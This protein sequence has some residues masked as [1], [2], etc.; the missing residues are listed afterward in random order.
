MPPFPACHQQK[1]FFFFF[2]FVTIKEIDVVVEI[3]TNP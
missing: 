3:F 1:D 2:F